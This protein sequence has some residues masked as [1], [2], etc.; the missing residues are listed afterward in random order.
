MH[1]LGLHIGIMIILSSHRLSTCLSRAAKFDHNHT[2]L[3]S[4][5]TGE[6]WYRTAGLVYIDIYIFI[7]HGTDDAR[8]GDELGSRTRAEKRLFIRCVWWD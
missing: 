5:M 1:H 6:L 8:P 3:P 4:L 7:K 2:A